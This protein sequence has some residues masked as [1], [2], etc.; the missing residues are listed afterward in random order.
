[1]PVKRCTIN[2]KQT[3][4]LFRIQAAIVYCQLE[5]VVLLTTKASSYNTTKIPGGLVLPADDQV[6]R[7][8]VVHRELTVCEVECSTSCCL[9]VNYFVPKL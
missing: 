3:V 6:Y 2:R 1:M 5:V 8:F 7:S 9:T 4:S